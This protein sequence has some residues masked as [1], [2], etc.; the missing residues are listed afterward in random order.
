MKL[1][2]QQALFAQDA[3][4]LIIHIGATPGY[5]CTLGEA[6]RHPMVAEYNATAG[7]GIKNSLHIERLAI[8]INLFKDGN[9]ITSTEA[10][11]AFGEFWESLDPMNRWG[12]RFNDGNHFERRKA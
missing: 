7:A 4:K 3:A 11:R 10:F 8:D 9:Y 2:E 5:S 12:G 6:W 1:S